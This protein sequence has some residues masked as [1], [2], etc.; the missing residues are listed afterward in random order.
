MKWDLFNP[1][2][3]YNYSNMPTNLDVST[4]ENPYIQVI[5]EDT[6]ENFTQE[7]IKSVKQY[8]MKK[9]SSTNINVITK[10]KTSDE[11]SMQT[12]DVSVNI[13]DKNYQTELVK[14][15]LESKGQEQYID[16]LMNIDLAVENR[17]LANEVEVTPFKR[18]Y[19]KKIEFDNFLS[20][21]QNQVIDF[22]KCNGITVVESDPPNFGGKTVLTVDLLLFLFFNTTT[23]TQKAEE[24]FNRF[25][26]VNKVS[27][28]GDI[29]IDGEDYVIVRQIE[30]KKSKAGEWNIKTELE[31]FKKLAD[32]Q[33]QNFTGEQRR[34]TENFMKKSI[35]SMEDFLMTIVT[36][37]SNLEDLLDAKPTARGQVLTRFLGLEF[38][39]KKEETGKELYSEFSKGMISNVYNTESLKQDNETSGE[40]IIRMK[41][42]IIEMSKNISDVDKR[43]QKGQDYKDNLLKSKFTDLDKELITLNPLLLQSSISNLEDSKQKT[44]QDIKSIKIVEPKEFYHE[45]KHDNVK[46]VIKSRFAELVTCENKVEEIQDLIE[47]YGDGIQC[48]H[49]GIKLMEAKLTNEKIKQLDS[50]KRLV[51]DFKE[52]IDGY[53][54]KEQSFTQLKKDFDEYERNK[55]IKEKY[56]LSLESTQLKLEQV[57][58][59]LKR[60]EEVQDKI[61]K[62]NEIDAQLL[63]AGLRIDE[64]INE[65]RGY[66]KVQNTNS[67]RIETIE[68]R[69]EKNKDLISKIAEEFER[70]KIYKIYVEVYGKNGITKVIM[71]TMMP[72]INSEL[73][74]LL[75]DSAYFN[76][77]IRINDKNEVE[78]IMIDNGTGIEKPMTAGSGYEKTVG[79]LAIRSVLAKVCSLPKPN[80]VVMDEVFGKISNDNL[81][82]VGE[83][84]GKI[85][86]Y[87]GKVLVI[88][89]NQLINNWANSTIRIT[90]SDNIS[91]VSQ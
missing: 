19:I 50:F 86:E 67:T 84:F 64:L 20:Y 12:I 88:S 11:D 31:F 78:F 75:Q 77:E 25:T 85:K 80:I 70:E 41:D 10:V 17:M 43:L 62:N 72:L 24:I 63:K 1:Y 23:K 54:K 47:K 52:E 3:T 60:Y 30:R 89:H 68:S 26:D 55:L 46:E 27:V 73:Q 74:R 66:E 42:E 56:E 35:G 79:S 65:K 13:M 22:D 33:L 61:K 38:L 83:F 59:K 39:K 36:T 34:E 57:K 9:Y 53:E 87:F 69:I 29:T 8:F 18:W 32:G 15:Y 90:K 7:R 91:K 81:E 40:E 58:D 16:Q 82:L 5:W 6:P 48:D 14:T 44:E 49:C 2:P 45:D 71:K 51:Q 28:K 21:G 4:L 37:A 76:L